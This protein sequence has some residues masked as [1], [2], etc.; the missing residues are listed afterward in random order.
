MNPGAGISQSRVE[1][2]GAAEREKGADLVVHLWSYFSFYMPEESLITPCIVEG[3][4]EVR[5]GS[6]AGLQVAR[7]DCVLMWS[8]SAGP[9][10]CPRGRQPGLLFQQTTSHW[11]TGG[12]PGPPASLPGSVLPSLFHWFYFAVVPEFE[13][14]QCYIRCVLV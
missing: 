12:F 9:G 2:M 14:K 8:V 3:E 10:V 5:G 7:E 1:S 6:E 4:V 11:A 13:H